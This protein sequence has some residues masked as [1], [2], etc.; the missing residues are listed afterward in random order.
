MTAPGRRSAALPD[1][2][3]AAPEAAAAPD[4]APG[5]PTLDPVSDAPLHERM[6][7]E[8][9]EATAQ[10]VVGRM[11][12]DGNTQPFGLLHGG[13]T[14]VLGEGLASI[15]A[16]LHGRPERVGVGIELNATHHRAVTSGWVTGTATALQLGRTVACY[17]IT[18]RDDAERL[19]CTLRVTCLLQPA[20]A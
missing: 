17:A 7:I 1:G 10:R 19:V 20:R 14:C 16:Y 2:P 4:E 8:I 3:A 5:A 6:G 12:V 13:A 9:L 18:V 15:G 11:P